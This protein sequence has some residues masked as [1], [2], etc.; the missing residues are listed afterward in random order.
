MPIIFYIYVIVFLILFSVGSSRFVDA[1]PM[2]KNDL[3]MELVPQ[4]ILSK[5]YW[6]KC[7]FETWRT[8]KMCENSV[9]IPDQLLMTFDELN[10]HV[11][12]FIREVKKKWK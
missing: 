5:A 8:W 3:M 9:V 11:S 4:S 6:Q 12:D 7:T 1:Q 10:V 2:T